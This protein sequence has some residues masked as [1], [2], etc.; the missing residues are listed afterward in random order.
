MKELVNYYNSNPYKFL[1]EYLDIELTPI[2][3]LSLK[4]LLLGQNGKSRTT[5]TQEILNSNLPYKTKKT[6]IEDLWR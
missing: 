5:I 4:M 3:R 2:Q 6:L 1:A